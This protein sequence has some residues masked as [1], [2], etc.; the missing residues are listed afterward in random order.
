[1]LFSCIVFATVFVATALSEPLTMPI[2]VVSENNITEAHVRMLA[3]GENIPLKLWNGVAFYGSVGVG[4]PK[5]TINFIFDSGSSNLWVANPAGRT[6]SCPGSTER[7]YDHTLSSSYHRMGLP[8]A[9]RYGT[10]GVTG[11]FSKDDIS[12]DD[13]HVVKG[14]IFGEANNTDPMKA[15][16]FCD[17]SYSGILGMGWPEI[18]QGGVPT[19]MEQ[20]ISQNVFTDHSFSFYLGPGS[21]ELVLGG[22][23][24]SH[25]SGTL[26]T[27]AVNKEG[28][29]QAAGGGAT[30]NGAAVNDG[31]A[32]FVVD[33]GTSIVVVPSSAFT[34]IKSKLGLQELQGKL[35]GDCS[36]FNKNMVLTF[37]GQTFTV[38][39]RDWVLRE[40]Q[41]LCLMGIQSIDNLN[42]WILGFPFMKHYYVNF[43]IGNKQMHI[44]PSK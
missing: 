37:G 23:D 16:G 24:P 42:L 31:G 3:A 4:T 34:D 15:G 1:M 10:G 39:L 29:W 14:F 2:K 11:F 33:S 17:A 36:L 35:F 40:V 22:T 25:Y 30:I 38:N 5:Q 43:D 44:A 13:S 9:I 21:P 12:L 19:L 28:Y 18:A 26:K 41:G 6:H 20:A 7:V 8:F 27:V 32:D